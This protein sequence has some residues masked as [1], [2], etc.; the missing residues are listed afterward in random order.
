MTR[1]VMA[2]MVLLVGRARAE[3]E[4]V[5]LAPTEGPFADAFADRCKTAEGP[6]CRRI[7]SARVAPF[8][9][10]E[11]HGG[12]QEG[13]LAIEHGGQ[14]FVGP[15]L[16][17][18]GESDS[19]TNETVAI[20]FVRL[21]SEPSPELGTLAVLR[22]GMHVRVVRHCSHHAEGCVP[23]TAD[24]AGRRVEEHDDDRF[25]VCGV[26]GSGPPRCSPPIAVPEELVRR[27]ALTAGALVLSAACARF[28]WRARG[29]SYDHGVS[30]PCRYELTAR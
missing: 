7:A 20:T 25:V 1:L 13:H 17:I 11:F 6:P 26:V 9:R 23:G 24:Y 12:K 21:T 4:V 27:P 28:D 3:P 18:G 19:T 16:S 15:T 5:T 14:W 10:V 29:R 8:Q 22:I 30:E 2:L